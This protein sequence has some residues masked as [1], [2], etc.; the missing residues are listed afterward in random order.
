MKLR[1]FLAASD[2]T[3]SPHLT[4]PVTA[5][6]FNMPEDEAPLPYMVCWLTLF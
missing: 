1:N 4:L 6:F 5:F 3:C 2:E